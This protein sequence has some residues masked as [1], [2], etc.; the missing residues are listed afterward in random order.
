MVEA[1]VPALSLTVTNFNPNHKYRF[2]MLMPSLRWLVELAF[3]GRDD[4]IYLAPRVQQD[5]ML[6]GRDSDENPFEISV[7]PSQ[8][9][10]LSLHDSGIVNLTAARRR[11]K[12]RHQPPDARH[13]LL[14]TLGIKDSKGLQRA[15]Q[16]EVNSLPARY[17]VLPVAGL[18]HA[19][20]VYF[21]IFRVPAGPPWAMPRMSDTLQMRFECV[22]R[23]KNVKYEFVVWQNASI[24]PWPGD[25]AISFLGAA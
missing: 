5:Y 6:V 24:A 4:S 19:G 11:I 13:G 22:L 1:S 12:I 15:T 10:H 2:L 21:T 8:D 9:L 18:P 25:V 14:V 23:G 16:N 3:A 7:S 20:P 17:S